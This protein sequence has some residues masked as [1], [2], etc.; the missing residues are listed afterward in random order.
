MEENKVRVTNQ[1]NI[2]WLFW[3]AGFLFTIG[4]GAMD[5]IL[6]VQGLS[7]WDKLLQG[8]LAYITWPFILGV[9]FK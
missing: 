9:Y 5:D 4:I 2:A 6:F 7:F 1:T 8:A 3:M